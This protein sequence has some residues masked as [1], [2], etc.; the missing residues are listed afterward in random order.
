MRMS[1]SMQLQEVGRRKA[2]ADHFEPTLARRCCIAPCA[3]A[4]LSC[5]ACYMLFSE[6]VDHAHVCEHAASGSR[7]PEQTILS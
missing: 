2:R 5:R 7:W 3:S 1:V 4:S 6:A